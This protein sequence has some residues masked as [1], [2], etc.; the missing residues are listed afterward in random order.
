[1][2]DLETKKVHEDYLGGKS[3]VA[4]ALQSGLS[5]STIA[6]ILINKHKATETV[7][8]SASLRGVRST[9]V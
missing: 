6:M 3:V 7:E 2:I 9:K 4:I 8:G 5:H 1:M